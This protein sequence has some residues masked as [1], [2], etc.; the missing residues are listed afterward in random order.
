MSFE[1]IEKYECPVCNDVG[2]IFTIRDGH[3]YCTP[4]GCQEIKIAMERLER[5]GLAKEFKEKTFQNYY[6]ENNP[7]LIDAKH[8]VERYADE[9]LTFKHE[10]HNSLMLCGQVGAGKTHLGTACSIK[11]IHNGTAV[12]YMG[13]RDEMTELKASILDSEKYNRELSRYKKAPVLFIDDFLKGK[14]TESDVNIIYEIVNY[15]Y[16]NNLPII[17]STEKTPDALINFDEA[18]ASRLIEM[19]RGNIIFFKGKELN[20]RLYGGVA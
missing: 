18:I 15:R 3:E 7:I 1:N 13:Y 5:S 6:T 14:V 17:I 8:T 11:L 12:I 4:C 16:N 10:R 19:C 2:Y 20:Y 9:F